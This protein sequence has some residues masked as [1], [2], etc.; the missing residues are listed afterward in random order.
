MKRVISR[1]KSVVGALLLVVS[2]TVNAVPVSAQTSSSSLSITPRKNYVIEPGKSVNDTMV[3]R[4]LDTSNNLDLNLNVIDFTYTNDSGTPKLLLGDNI[5]QTTWSLKPF[6]TVP[7]SVSIPAG[8][9]KTINLS[10]K[11]PSNQG[12]GSYYSAIVYSSGSGQGGNVGLSASGVTLV[13]AQVPGSVSEGLKLKNLGTYQQNVQ[14]PGYTTFNINMPG[15]IGYTLQNNG[16]VTEAP[17]GSIKL[18]YM[19]GGD[20]NIDNINPNGSLALI[21]Q[22]RTYTAC[23]KLKQQD[24]TLD[25]S[26]NTTNTC[27]APSLWPGIYTVSLDAFY[28]Q[29]GNQTQ[30]VTGSGWFIYFPVWAMIALVALILLIIFFVWRTRVNLRRWKKERAEKKRS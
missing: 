12:A 14:N 9:T 19:F 8:Q 20:T 4:N 5:P 6:L 22:T 21:G 29:N 13:F 7:E 26:T 27:V 2:L 24:V 17:A 30:E 10:V 3:V 16:N 18:H 11:I 25:D 28:G 23:I 1:F 15:Q